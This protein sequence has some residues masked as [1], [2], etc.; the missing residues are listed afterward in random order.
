MVLCVS[1]VL[2]SPAGLADDGTPTEPYPELEVT[3][4]WYR[5]RA[6]VD[7]P[8]ERAIRRGKIR[9][10]RK[11]AVA[12]AR[13]VSER[14]E[15]AEILEAYDSMTLRLSGN[16]CNLAP[17]HAR[18]GFV[19]TPFVAT[20]DK[21]TSDGGNV[22]LMDLEVI[23]AYPIAYIEFIQRDGEMDRE[24]PWCEKEE[25]RH[26]RNWEIRRAVEEE[27]LQNELQKKITLYERY[28]IRA[29]LHAGGYR[30]HEWEGAPDNIA[31]LY[32]ALEDRENASKFIETLDRGDAAWLAEHIRT[33]NERL[34]ENMREEVEKQLESICP[35]RT[36]KS[37]RVVLMRDARWAKRQPLRTVQVTVW[38]VLSLT[39]EEG[40]RPGHFAP[41]QQ[42][43]VSNLMPSQPGAWMGVEP[44]AVVY[45]TARR[46]ARWTPVKRPTPSPAAYSRP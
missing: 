16:S 25:A 19:K 8:L 44:D 29:Q 4:G 27:K 39:F 2:W 15:P 5:L 36:V 41:G 14:K 6:V 22:T 24:G 1:N 40:G 43:L 11:I 18:L 35:P 42:F 32:E 26:H 31:D 28:A 21:L 37:F 45:L 38:D 33:E 12:S 20:L 17:W 34:E 23:K 7:A 46:D 13:L 10:G 9:V 30:I 3:D